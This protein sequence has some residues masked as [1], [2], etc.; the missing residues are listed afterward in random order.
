MNRAVGIAHVIFESP[1]ASAGVLRCKRLVVMGETVDIVRG[2]NGI[3]TASKRGNNPTPLPSKALYSKDE[4]VNGFVSSRV[5]GKVDA[6]TFGTGMRRAQ[7]WVEREF[8]EGNTTAALTGEA[9]KNLLHEENIV[10]VYNLPP[11]ANESTIRALFEACGK[12][13]SLALHDIVAG[14]SR[15]ALV[16]F[17]SIEGVHAAVADLD[18]LRR[19]GSVLRV[20]PRGVVK[21]DY[22]MMKLDESNEYAK[23]GASNAQAGHK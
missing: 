21:D 13:K 17:T 14:E 8:V 6:F 20:K 1:E 12:I 7:Y 3:G 22:Q 11:K 10:A 18:G 5:V 23:L 16:E 4:Q 19:G 2:P 15:Y 9:S